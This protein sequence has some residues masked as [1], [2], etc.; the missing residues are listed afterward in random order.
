MRLSYGPA[1]G[2]IVATVAKGAV[3]ESEDDGTSFTKFSNINFQPGTSWKCCGTLYEVPAQVGS[4]S[5]GTLLFAASF[6][7]GQTAS[8]DV[9]SSS[10]GGKDWTYHSTPVRRGECTPHKGLWEPHFEVAADGALVMF[11]SDET[12]PC[13]S[14]KLAQI[15]SRDGAT[16]KDE[17]NTV[18][19]NIEP[20][21]PGMAW[22]TKTPAGIYFMTY[23][24]C[25]PAQCTVFSRTSRDGWNFGPPSNTGKKIETV[26]GAY[27]EHAPTTISISHSDSADVSLLV[28]GQMLYERSGTVSPKNG[29]VL[30]INH[31]SDGSGPWRTMPAPVKVPDARNDPCPNYSSVLLPVRGGSALLEIASDFNNFQTCV[32]YYAIEPLQ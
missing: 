31:S 6:C 27:F 18:A 16:W 7:V 21:R 29:Q 9:Y 19:S 4:L 25:G 20:D 12:D 26:S 3:Y 11:W 10:N 15:R 23:E 1:K 13:C 24:L 22:V 2:K 14:Q 5:A 28:V 8:I 17:K 32:A 30:F